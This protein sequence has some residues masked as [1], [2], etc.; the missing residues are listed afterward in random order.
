MRTLPRLLFAVVVLALPLAAAGGPSSAHSTDTNSLFWRVK[1]KQVDAQFQDWDMAK[2]LKKIASATGWKVYVEPGTAQRVSVKFKNLPEDEALRR[3]LGK[4]N[5]FRD[6]TNG[7][8]RLFVF[9]TVSGAATQMVQAE[10]KDY[11]IPK[12]SFWSR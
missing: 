11:R 5:Y 10:K 9:Q 2:V 1:E 7:V 8:S 4:L 6:E 3:L 12:M